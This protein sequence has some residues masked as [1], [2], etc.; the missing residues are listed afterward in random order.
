MKMWMPTKEQ[1]DRKFVKR[2]KQW[3]S[4][5]AIDSCDFWHLITRAIA[6][7]EGRIKIEGDGYP[8]DF[9]LI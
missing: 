9:K 7:H 1:M 8:L 6:E 3:H 5:P 2:I 4:N